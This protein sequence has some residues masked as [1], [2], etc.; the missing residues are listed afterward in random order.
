MAVMLRSVRAINRA[1]GY[2]VLIWCE[3]RRLGELTDMLESEQMTSV[4]P[5]Y[6]HKSDD[7]ALSVPGEY[8][9]T[10]DSALL[11]WV[12]QATAVRHMMYPAESLQNKQNYVEAAA[13]RQPHK[14]DNGERV[15]PS[16]KNPDVYTTL[17][18]HYLVAGDNVM[19]I[20]GGGCAEMEAAIRH[21]C[22]V[23]AV[24]PN[25]RRAEYMNKFLLNWDAQFQKITTKSSK[26]KRQCTEEPCSVCGSEDEIVQV[27]CLK[28]EKTCCE[29]CMVE[30]L[31]KLCLA[32]SAKMSGEMLAMQTPVVRA[33]LLAATH[34]EIA[35]I[36]GLGGSVAP[37]SASNLPSKSS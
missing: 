18:Q 15:C 25:K 2:L 27:Y 37:F 33:A 31:C 24:E 8:H 19:V 36:A 34:P 1:K 22:N 9:N 23:V 13:V 21:G 12:P 3:W 7:F 10:V 17:L 20:R 35:D 6:W 32:A 16:Q 30:D 26:K 28:C 5:F 4:Q 14:F 11:V 29:G